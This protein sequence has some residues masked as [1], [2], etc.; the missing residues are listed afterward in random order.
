MNREQM[1]MRSVRRALSLTLL[2]LGASCSGTST[3][4]DGLPEQPRKALPMGLFKSVGGLQPGQNPLSAVNTVSSSQ[5]GISISVPWDLCGNDEACLLDTIKALLDGASAKSLKVALAISDGMSTPPGVKARCQLFSFA[6]RST[7]QT[8]CLAWDADYLTAKKA[9]VKVFGARFDAHPALAYVYFTGACSTN[10]NEGHCRI[11]E[12]AYTAAGYTASRLADAYIGIMDAYLEALPTTPIAFEVHAIFGSAAPWTAIWNH[13]RPT[14]RVGI[15]AWWC[16]ERLSV[17]G[18]ET[19]PVWPLLQEAAEETFSVCQ[20]V[21]N[22]ST[23]PWRFSDP[24]LGL[25]Y[26]TEQSMDPED[27]TR[28]FNETLDWAEGKA[29]HARQPQPIVRFRVLEPWHS[30]M[31]NPAFSDRWSS[32]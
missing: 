20:T 1:N 12:Q 10:G 5:T 7:P 4:P 23:E 13:V 14:K 8:M 28:A 11:D 29:V 25:D 17:N 9:F 27:V 24:T 18:A 32:F 21:G 31:T 15:A 3:E 19:T 16:A 26:G 2:T 6:F 22:L 30:D